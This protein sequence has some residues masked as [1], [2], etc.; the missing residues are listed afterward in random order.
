MRDAYRQLA[1]A[2]EV[3]QSWLIDA[4]K[5]YGEFYDDIMPS[6]RIESYVIS[7]SWA[8]SRFIIEADD[9]QY[10]I[11]NVLV[12]G[13]GHVSAAF[14]LWNIY[15]SGAKFYFRKGTTTNDWG[16]VTYPHF[17]APHIIAHLAYLHS[18]CEKVNLP[19]IISS[20][21]YY[22]DKKEIVVKFGS[23]S[24]EPP[25]HFYIHYPLEGD[26]YFHVKITEGDRNFAVKMTN[27]EDFREFL[28]NCHTYAG[29]LSL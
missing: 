5:I 26:R 12:K 28:R 1:K 16:K 3:S 10:E 24:V 19:S 18:H 27:P 9:R 23:W 14:Y 7:L 6:T 11:A 4:I 20:V 22:P 13:N 21:L 17:V 15:Y 29:V 8:E 2:R 25:I